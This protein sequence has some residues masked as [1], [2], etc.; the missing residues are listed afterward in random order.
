[1]PAQSNRLMHKKVFDKLQEQNHFAVPSI[2]QA[3]LILAKRTLEIIIENKDHYY[4]L[5]AITQRQAW[6]E[7][8]IYMMEAIEQTSRYTNQI[9]DEITDQMAATLD[10]GKKEIN[11]F[12]TTPKAP[13]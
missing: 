2:S 8:I 12:L 10:Y 6:K 3:K 13:F 7:W 1:M 11:W 5:S 9:I 4:N